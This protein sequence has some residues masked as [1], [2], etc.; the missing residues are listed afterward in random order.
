MER[1]DSK[2]TTIDWLIRILSA[3]VSI[4]VMVSSWTLKQAWDRIDTIDKQVHILEI[5]G[6]ETA[7][8]KF[9]AAD[10]AA[11]KA[12]LDSEKMSLDRRIMRLEESIPTIKDTL[13]EI[14]TNQLEIKKQLDTK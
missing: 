4:T 3:V 14:K 2:T 11:Q 9:T 10:W 5:K 1:K 7:G 8:S 12:L 13:L 6:A